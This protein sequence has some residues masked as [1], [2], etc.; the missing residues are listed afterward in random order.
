MFPKVPSSDT[1][2]F[3]N[4]SLNPHMNLGNVYRNGVISIF[5][6]QTETLGSEDLSD[7]PQ[8]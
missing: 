4:I 8:N 1:L 6:L 2:K 3:S 5:I 7:L